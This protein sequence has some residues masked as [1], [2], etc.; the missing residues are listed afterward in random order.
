MATTVI[1]HGNPVELSGTPPEIGALA[2]AFELT[3]G[4]MSNVK[5]S[6]S[7]GKIRILSIIPSIDTGV[8]AIQTKRFNQEF[9]ALP[10]SIVGYT[11]SVDTPFAQN[12]WCAAEGVE[13]MKLLSDY[14]GQT[15]GRDYGLYIGD[16]G[17]L[18]R[19]VMIVDGKGEVAYFQLVP[20]ISQEPDYT[21]VLE[22][23][24]ELAA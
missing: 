6:D 1:F 11:V 2:P 5:L 10:D 24:R 19:S 3:G 8:C 13:K 22:K 15:F 9:D 4:D 23:A 14:K 17:L 7:D 20:D 12:R 16:L 18:A 21:E